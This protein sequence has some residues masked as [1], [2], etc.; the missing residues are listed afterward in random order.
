MSSSLAI[1]DFSRAA[2]LTVKTLHHYHETGLLEPSQID[3]QTG[4]RRYT[5]EQIPVAQI[6]KRFRGLD[7]TGPAQW[8][9]ESVA[10]FGLL[11]IVLGHRRT[12]DVPWMVAGWIDAAYWFTASTSSANPAI[13]I[14]RSLSDTFSGIRPADVP[15]FIVAQLIG[16]I[17]ALLMAR[18]LFSAPANKEEDEK[19]IDE[20]PHTQSAS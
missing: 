19:S 4:Y 18:V 13:T 1:G 2:H 7:K 8:L 9:A 6:I 14:A 12:Q 16:A 3:P 17:A 15:A 10:I 20:A 11:L 5:T